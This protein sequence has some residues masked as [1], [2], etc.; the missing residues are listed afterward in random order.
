MILLG[1]SFGG[2]LAALYAAEFPERV[3]ALVLVAPSGLLVLPDAEGEF[4][5]RIRERLPAD[6]R[7]AYDHF[8]REYLDFG[9]VFAK[10][11][12]ELATMNRRLGEYFLAASGEQ[13]AEPLA[14]GGGWMVQ[15]LYFS[16]GKRHDYRAALRGAGSRAGCPRRE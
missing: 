8:L 13:P 3:R 4:F 9:G 6:Q 10:T 1:H 7:D 15:A 2:F 11:E 14:E 5:D 12:A 16:M